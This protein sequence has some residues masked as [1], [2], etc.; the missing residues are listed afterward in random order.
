MTINNPLTGILNSKVKVDCLRHLCNYPVE[1]NGTQL[2]KLLKS[3]PRSVHKA[4]SA[5]VN[6]GVVSLRPHGNS[7]EYSINKANWIVKQLLV[8]VFIDEKVFLEKLM[9]DIKT[10]IMNCAVRES[11]LSVVLFG[12]VHRKEENSRSDLDIFVLVDGQDQVGPVE[13]EMEKIGTALLRSYG[14]NLGP[15]VKSLR[16]FQRDQALGVI[17]SILSSHQLVYGKEPQQYVR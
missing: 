11:I 15:Y 8:P 2:S 16:S 10:R 3:T 1:L 14:I 5:L 6:E 4:M 9:K 7:F 13:E 17:K 12:S